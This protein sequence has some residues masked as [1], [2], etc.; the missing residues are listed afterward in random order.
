MIPRMTPRVKPPAKPALI[1]VM[2]ATVGSGLL[3]YVP[4]ARI[5]AARA[6]TSAAA[7]SAPVGEERPPWAPLPS[8]WLDDAG[9]YLPAPPGGPDPLG[10]PVRLASSGGEGRLLP[11]GVAA[12]DVDLGVHRVRMAIARHRS[13]VRATLRRAG[14]TQLEELYLRV[15]KQEKVVEVWA[16]SATQERFVKV[17]QFAICEVSGKPGPKR[18]QGDWQ[19]PEGFYRIDRLNPRSRYDLSVHVNYP[20]AADRIRGRGE[21]NLGGSIFIHGGC[22]SVGCVAITNSGIEELYAMV[23][24]LPPRRRHS[25]P[26]AIYPLRL[27]EKGMRWLHASYRP[28]PEDY[29]FWTNL[30]QGFDAF[31]RTHR[32]PIVHVASDGSYAFAERPA[33][34]RLTLHLEGAAPIT[35]ASVR[36]DGSVPAASSS[37][38]S[39]R[40]GAADRTDVGDGAG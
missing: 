26:V 2:A 17:R 7:M 1:L 23:L 27:N 9:Q 33:P 32:P 14:V 24:E 8:A 21:Q 6:A 22:A 15:F 40:S 38:P 39:T 30:K 34:A 10:Q 4:A 11:R 20:N 3:S 18:R 31:E 13:E 35:S 29:A 36:S 5:D 12:R 37:T 28:A 16:R 19:V 25:V